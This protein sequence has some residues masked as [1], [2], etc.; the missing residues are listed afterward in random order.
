M[1]Q[2]YPPQA[3]GQAGARAGGQAGYLGSADPLTGPITASSPG[4]EELVA[5]LAE[6]YAYPDTSW[7]RAN[8]ITSVD[9]AV[10]LDGRS[11][12][13]S[14]VAD[15][16][17]FS[18]LRGLADVILVGAGTARAEHYGLARADWPTLREGRPE[19]PPIAIVTG[20]LALD[21]DSPL[22]QGDS[23]HPRTIVLTTCQAP[24]DRV[25]AAS[26]TADV[27]S[28]GSN[29]VSGKAAIAK[30]T[31]LGYQRILVEGGPTLLGELLAS[32]LL[33]EL[34]M[35][36]SPLL[37]GGESARMITSDQQISPARLQLG[38]VLEDDGFLLCR[39]LRRD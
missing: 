23:D 8:M 3:G 26:R 28:T 10:S 4:A 6:V 20:R 16:L 25:A 33:D 17:L 18:V 32:D 36:Y 14:G 38:S 39:Y 31:E 13:L 2:I 22:L 34:C 11:G 27:I 1:R 35:T 12:G 30:L 15:R 21:L 19:V 37:E 7:V 24:A 9:G 5:R 29:R